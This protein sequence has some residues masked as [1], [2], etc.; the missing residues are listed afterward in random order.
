MFMYFQLTN[1]ST[2]VCLL[3]YFIT[4]NFM[5][6]QEVDVLLFLQVTLK[7]L[8]TYNSSFL[9]QKTIAVNYTHFDVQ[10]LYPGTT[11][12]FNVKTE[13]NAFVGPASNITTAVTPY[14]SVFLSLFYFTYFILYLLE[15]IYLQNYLAYLIFFHTLE[16]NAPPITVEKLGMQKTVLTLNSASDET[17]PIRQAWL[18]NTIKQFYPL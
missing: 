14:D 8:K 17:G 4:G 10:N 5:S 1:I 12:F 18:K 15:F 7:G 6:I 2:G 3:K 16:P 9:H 13:N 11:Y